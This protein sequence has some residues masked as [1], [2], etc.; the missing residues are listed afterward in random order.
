MTLNIAIEDVKPVYLGITNAQNGPNPTIKLDADW[1]PVDALGQVPPL[2]Q[3]QKDSESK[4]FNDYPQAVK[5]AFL[6]LENY[7]IDRIKVAKGI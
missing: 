3:Q 7:V 1:L 2:M 6:I 4:P 5:D